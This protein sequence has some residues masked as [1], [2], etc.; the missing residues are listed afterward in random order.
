MRK[1]SMKFIE[2]LN[3]PP[4]S[5]SLQQQSVDLVSNW[6]YNKSAIDNI[7]NL[8]FGSDAI[9]IVLA[10]Q[11]TDDTITQLV[12]DQYQQY[13]DVK[14]GA[15]LSFFKNERSYPGCLPPHIHSVRTLALNF[16]IVT[17]GNSVAT[18]LFKFKHMQPN[19]KF[20]D[21]YHYDDL[22]F[23]DHVICNNPTWYAFES[24]KPHSVEN[25]ESTRILLAITFDPECKL[26]T[27]TRQKNINYKVIL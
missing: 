17:G 18:T 13:F 16:Y 20:F 12:Q 5:I 8:V 27:I 11:I 4:P 21:Y 2:L 15:T 22:E 1:Y 6:K 23:Q 25:I 24:S 26:D 14:L 9:N 19:S 3:L 7:Q 10:G